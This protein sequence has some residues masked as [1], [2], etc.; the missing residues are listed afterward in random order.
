M[1]L[2]HLEQIQLGINKENLANII[3]KLEMSEYRLVREH[4]IPVVT[5][6]QATSYPQAGLNLALVDLFHHGVAK[7]TMQSLIDFSVSC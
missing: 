3:N 5:D 2:G 1:V 7:A 4:R 6:I